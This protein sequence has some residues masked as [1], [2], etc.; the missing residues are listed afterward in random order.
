LAEALAF[1]LARRFAPGTAITVA[2]SGGIDSMVL[3]HALLLARASF[4]IALAAHHVCHG[5]SPHAEDWAAFCARQCQTLGVPLGTTRLALSRAPQQSIEALARE[6]RHAALRSLDCAV[7]AL[8]HHADDQAETVLLQL[9]RGAG[10]AGLAAMPELDQGH[11][12]FW[13]P[14]LGR[15]R[16]EIAAWAKQRELAWV[17]DESNADL[18]LRRNFL[19]HEITP[20]L[21]KV[22]PGYAHNLARSARHCA[23]AADLLQQLAALDGL[24][25]EA[26]EGLPL[27]ALR[28]LPDARARNL[29]RQFFRLAGL[30]APSEAR[31]AAFLKAALSTRPDARTELVHEETRLMRE[32]DRLVFLPR[33]PEHFELIW[34]GESELELPHGRLRFVPATGHG[35]SEAVLTDPR[36]RI[37]PC[38]SG[39]RIWRQQDARPQAVKELLR[40]AGVPAW[41]RPHWPAVMVADALVAVAGLGS[42]KAR[43]CAPDERGWTLHW[44]PAVLGQG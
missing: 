27:D 18:G 31:L 41:A 13:R 17:E 25:G 16:A 12:A 8:A 37:C 21:A 30:V 39:A 33:A 10:V 9:L 1:E 15:T 23:E 14:L 40:A 29:L 11:P 24:P 36:C 38:P 44:Q 35:L 6:A 7:V 20:E 42:A 5:I 3:L 4:P 2:L 32:G 19:R 26:K 28:S 34:R 43:A 22:F